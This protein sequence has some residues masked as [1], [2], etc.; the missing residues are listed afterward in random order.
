MHITFSG[1][2]TWKS[3][4][5]NL[6]IFDIHILPSIMIHYDEMFDR[7]NDYPLEIRISWFIWVFSIYLSK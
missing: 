1:Y 3:I 2:K 6:N 5:E 7:E 4:K